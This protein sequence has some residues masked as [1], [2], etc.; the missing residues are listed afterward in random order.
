MNTKCEKRTENSQNFF[1]I[2]ENNSKPENVL[3]IALYMN[4][5]VMQCWL[6]H[7]SCKPWKFFYRFLES[8]IV[9]SH[10]SVF[11]AVRGRFNNISGHWC[12]NNNYWE[13]ETKTQQVS[14]EKSYCNFKKEKLERNV[15]SL[16][17]IGFFKIGNKLGFLNDMN[18]KFFILLIRED[19][20]LRI[21]RL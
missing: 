3:E 21:V 13:N 8:F 7:F 4:V 5:S 16:P 20:F 19:F 15:A 2:I 18:F 12:C 1:F 17:R 11:I 9:L 14:V 10:C 6:L